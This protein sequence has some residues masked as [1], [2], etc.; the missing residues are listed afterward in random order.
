M[1]KP[2]S[3]TRPSTAFTAGTRFSTTAPFSMLT[4]FPGASPSS[5]RIAARWER[6]T[7]RT[8]ICWPVSDARKLSTCSSTNPLSAPRSTGIRGCSCSGVLS[9]TTPLSCTASNTESVSLTA[10]AFVTA[11]SSQTDATTFVNRFVSN[12]VRLP[13]TAMDATRTNRLVMTT[14]AMVAIFLQGIGVASQLSAVTGPVMSVARSAAEQ[15]CLRCR[16][17]LVAQDPLLLEGGELLQ[18]R[19]DVGSRREPRAGAV[20]LQP[21]PRPARRRPAGPS[22]ASGLV[23]ALAGTPAASAA[24]CCLPAECFDMPPTTAV[25]VP[26][27]TAVRA[28]VPTKPVG[29]FVSS[30]QCPLVPKGVSLATSIAA[31]TRS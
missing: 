8:M 2:R 28:I 29:P 11:G 16:E 20:R 7:A 23:A 13:Q 21:A 12:S 22:P 18:L 24:C 9:A 31:T 6:P 30:S 3:C 5:T 19:G 1:S 14:S 10:I 26:A 4:P 27:T 15:L 25:A 17:L